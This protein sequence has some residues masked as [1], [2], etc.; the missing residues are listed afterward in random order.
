M[1]KL[2]V[3]GLISLDGYMAGPGDDFTAM[4]LDDSFSGYNVERLRTADTLL[5]GRT[6]YL[7]FQDYWPPI[8][9]DDSQPDIER[10]ISRLNGAME[11][12]VV[13]DT[14]GPDDL[15]PWRDR[16]RIVRRADAR[17]AV[18]ELR[19]SEGRDILMFGSIPL[20]NDLLAAGLVDELHLMVGNAAVGGGTPAFHGATDR[21]RLLGA[22]RLP[23]SDNMLL[24]YAAA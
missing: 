12:V 20:W 7:G 17:D 18:A 21:L 3:C 8:A 16:T 11:K 5:L 13:S 2:I 9:A 15:G 6:T 4:P 1:R 23:D 19:R 10:E 22:R 14:I 24:T